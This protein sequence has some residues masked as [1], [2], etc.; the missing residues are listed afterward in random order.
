MQN[1]AKHAL[2]VVV[3]FVLSFYFQSFITFDKLLITVSAAVIDFGAGRGM[4]NYSGSW[5]WMTGKDDVARLATWKD[6]VDKLAVDF[7]NSRGI[8]YYN[9]GAWHWM[10][11]ASDVPEMVPWG[12]RLAVDLGTGV[13]IYNY[14]GSW[15]YMRTMSTE[16]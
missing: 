4:Y 2:I 13:G 9:N 11:N 5:N 15:N 10:K 6:G 16:E 3:V 14:N 8:Y 12:N 7:G 1:I